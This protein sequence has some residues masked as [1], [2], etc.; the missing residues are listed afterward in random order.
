MSNL[1]PIKHLIATQEVC[2]E[3]AKKSQGLHAWCTERSEMFI[4]HNA[5]IQ[6]TTRSIMGQFPRLVDNIR[7]RSG[8]DPF[9]I[10]LAKVTGYTV[11]TEEHGG[12]RG[13][14]IPDVCEALGLPHMKLL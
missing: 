13:P 10:A 14:K 3:L 2:E 4:E 11:V 12:G 7:G 6:K 9:V 5:D 1:I 8:G